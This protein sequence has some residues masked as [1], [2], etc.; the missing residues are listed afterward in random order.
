MK[1][2]TVPE[3]TKDHPSLLIRQWE[4]NEACIMHMCRLL[5][6]SAFS[7]RGV[8]FCYITKMKMLFNWN[9]F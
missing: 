1:I 5:T 7:E 4:G 9:S 2:S 6:F 8:V 3:L